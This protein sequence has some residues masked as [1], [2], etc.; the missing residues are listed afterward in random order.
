MINSSTIRGLG[1]LGGLWLLFLGAGGESP[2]AERQVHRFDHVRVCLAYD[3]DRAADTQWAEIK[4][5]YLHPDYDPVEIVNDV[6]LIRLKEPVRGLPVQVLY[7]K[8][9]RH[10]GLRAVFV[11]R[12]PSTEYGS[13]QSSRPEQITQRVLHLEDCAFGMQDNSIT[14]HQICT[15]SAHPNPCPGDSGGPLYLFDQRNQPVQVGIVSFTAGNCENSFSPALFTRVASYR[16]FI[17]HYVPGL[18]WYGKHLYSANLADGITVAKPGRYPSVVAILRAPF[19][20]VDR[21]QCGGTLIGDR[22]VLTAA[23]CFEELLEE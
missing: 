9:V 17:N 1:L 15:N 12:G 16:G 5:V 13:D 14:D 7:D 22:W 18:Q 11:G 2:A 8:P 20:S 23:H 10:E 6:A 4:E 3:V 21:L 19:T